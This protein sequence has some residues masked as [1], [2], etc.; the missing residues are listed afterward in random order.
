[1]AATAEARELAAAHKG[2][3]ARIGMRATARVH[4]LF[5]RHVDLTDL[6][7]S[8]TLFGHLFVGVVA[9]ERRAS[10]ALATRF[11]REARR[12]Q[13]TTDPG[14][15]IAAPM[16]QQQ[17]LL[18]GMVTGPWTVKR[19]IGLGM[20]P[21]QAFDVG[22]RSVRGRGQRW[23]VQGGRRVIIDSAQH[24]PRRTWRIVTDDDPCAFC[25]LMAMRT[26]P[27][28]G[29]TIRLGSPHFNSH[30]HCQCSTEEIFDGQDELTTREEAFI[31]AYLEA[32]RQADEHDGAR[33]AR[34]RQDTILWRMRRNRPE[35]FSDG[36]RNGRR[37]VNAPSRGRTAPDARGR[38]RLTQLPLPTPPRDESGR[39]VTVSTVR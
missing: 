25:A 2:M 12:L 14:L 7:G 31:D 33:S 19:K 28:T 10:Q 18:G 34:R 15:V 1:M 8:G 32:A 27:W 13:P 6:D 5:R 9:E 16:N 29:A 35:L 20:P 38:T 26:F 23:A 30:D 21:E 36:V 11:V 4:E 3:Q 22:L 39:F 17:A 37:D 24:S